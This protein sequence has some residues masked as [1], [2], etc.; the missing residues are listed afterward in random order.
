M[1]KEARKALEVLYF[2]IVA[3]QKSN[4]MM[5]GKRIN[6]QYLDLKDN[7]INVQMFLFFF[8]GEEPAEWRLILPF[9]YHW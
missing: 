1:D 6:E 4:I 7:M 9:F 3:H 2:L 5:Q 8:L